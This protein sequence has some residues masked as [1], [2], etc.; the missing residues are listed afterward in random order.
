MLSITLMVRKTAVIAI[1]KHGIEIARRI[2]ENMQ[3]VEIYA[4][5][6]YNISA[7]E[8]QSN[9]IWFTEQTTQLMTNLFKSNDALICIFSLGAVIRLIAPLLVD[10]R[11]D[12]AILVIDDKANFLKVHYQ[13][14]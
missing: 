8:S 4:P 14:T 5:A 9:I 1:T 11:S 10:K 6:K 7:S 13:D 12:P 2:K 3:E